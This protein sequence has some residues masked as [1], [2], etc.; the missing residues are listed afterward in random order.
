MIKE[1]SK[2]N[3]EDTVVGENVKVTGK[4]HTSGNIQINGEVKGEVSSDG[5]IIIGKTAMISGPITASDVKIEGT[6]KGNI[7]AS[8]EVALESNAKVF[9][10]IQTKTLSIKTGAVFVG[11][12]TMGEEVK[13]ASAKATAGKEE[14]KEPEP[15]LEIE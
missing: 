13:P 10:D 4:L 15:E 12:S 7:A 11:K 6:V 1:L 2:T 14:K 9:G 3:G 5:A 8:N